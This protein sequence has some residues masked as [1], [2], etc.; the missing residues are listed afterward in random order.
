MTDAVAL[1]DLAGGA[2]LDEVAR[3]HAVREQSSVS[4]LLA[5]ASWADQCG[6]GSF[7]LDL[8]NRGGERFVRLG[9][10]GTPRVAEFAPA[11]FGARLQLSPYAGARLIADVLDLRHRLPIL[12]GR[13]Q[14]LEVREGHARFVARKTRDLSIEQAAYVDE[15]VAE[16]ADGRLSWARFET[17]VEAAIVAADPDAAQARE[18]AAATEQF[19]K[20]TRSDEHG[21]RGFYVRADFATIARLDATVAYLAEALAAMGDTSTLDERRVKA[22]LILANPTQAVE[23]LKAYAESRSA[24]PIDES[25]LLPAIWLFVHT[26]GSGVARVEGMSPVTDE[27]V[28]THLGERCRFKITEAIDPMGQT[29]VDAY[30]IPDRHR[31]AVHLMTPADTFPFASSTSRRMQL[32]HTKEYRPGAPGQSRIGNYGPMITFHHRIKTHSGWHVEQPY[33]GIYV[34]RDPYGALYLVDHTGTRALRAA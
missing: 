14:R 15:R 30:E 4:I 12:W 32:D 26:S 28:R 3:L 1:D 33:P 13:V 10:A 8:V 31:Q 24:A 7:D 25:K 2:L 29:P 34:W 20:P 5:A 16:S 19:A 18:E 27:W 17:L 23:L 6:E 9:G 11:V 22:V 21:M